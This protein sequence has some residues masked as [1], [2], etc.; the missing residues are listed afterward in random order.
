MRVTIVPSDKFIRKDDNFAN[1]SEWNFNDSHIHAIQWY[2]NWGEVE[3]TG[4]PRPLNELIHNDSILQPYL[5]ALDEYLTSL[6][7][8]ANDNRSTSITIDT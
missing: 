7:N 4:N 5:V 2:D 3:Y 1:L 8:D 6:S